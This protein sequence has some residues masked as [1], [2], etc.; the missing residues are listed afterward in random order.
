VAVDLEAIEVE[1]WKGFLHKGRVSLQR[2][3]AIRGRAVHGIRVRICARR[4][5]DLR[6]GHVKEA[7]RIGGKRSGFFRID[8]VVRD[9]GDT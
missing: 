8:D 4:Q 5:V 7:Q 3:I 1:R 9:G 6:A 2:S